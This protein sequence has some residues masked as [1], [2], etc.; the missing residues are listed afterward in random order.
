MGGERDDDRSETVM[1]LRRAPASPASV[2]N[3]MHNKHDYYAMFDDGF[4]FV[5]W[6][7]H[8]FGACH[9]LMV[10]YGYSLCN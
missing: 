7:F 10:V 6:T 3:E 8:L 2:T 9:L 5:P 4:S 1:M